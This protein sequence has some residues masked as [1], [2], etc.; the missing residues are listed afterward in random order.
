MLTT[1]AG[2]SLLATLFSAWRNMRQWDEYH[3]G[4][5][6]RGQMVNKVFLTVVLGV[7]TIAFWLGRALF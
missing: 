2:V 7:A 4:H 1:V 5:V 3:R 6:T